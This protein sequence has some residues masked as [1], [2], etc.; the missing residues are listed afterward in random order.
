MKKARDLGLFNDESRSDLKDLTYHDLMLK[1][2]ELDESFDIIDDTAYYLGIER[3]STVIKHLEWLGLFSNKK[4]P[5]GNNVMD[6]FCELLQDKLSMEKNDLDLIVLYHRFI[7][8][9]ED[10]TELITSTLIDSGI[11]GGDSAM[12]RTVS[13]PAAIAATMLLQEE[14]KVRGVHIPV[15]PE[16][17]NPVL[18]ELGHLG[19]NFSEKTSPTTM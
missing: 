2:I 16:I 17:Y 8:E 1:L 5:A 11:P 3:H 18:E 6:V 12:S 9:Y 13:L 14:I 4:I 10:R 19:V 15:Q 7:A